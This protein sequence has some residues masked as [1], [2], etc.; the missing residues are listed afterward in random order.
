MRPSVSSNFSSFSIV[1]R[2]AFFPTLFLCFF[3]KANGKI[4]PTHTHTHGQTVVSSTAPPT[5]TPQSIT[6]RIANFWQFSGTIRTTFTG[7]GRARQQWEVVACLWTVLTVIKEFSQPFH[8]IKNRQ[9]IPFP[10]VALLLPC[11][12]A[13][14][15]HTHSHTPHTGKS[16]T[17]YGPR[18]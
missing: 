17:L 7:G 15:T 9:R 14:T 4:I 11:V 12:P 5:T 1:V 13:H 2:C 18:L 10:R 8:G 3:S 6:G 16:R